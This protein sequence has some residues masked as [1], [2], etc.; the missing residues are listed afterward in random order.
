MNS[1]ADSTTSGSEVMSLSSGTP[2]TPYTRKKRKVTPMLQRK[3]CRTVVRTPSG[4]PSPMKRPVRASP[5]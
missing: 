4:D 2:P 3:V 1:R 5:A